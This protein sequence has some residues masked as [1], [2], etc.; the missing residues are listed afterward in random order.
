MLR[1]LLGVKMMRSF[2]SA[3]AEAGDDG[4]H[5]VVT[6]L[7]ISFYGPGDTSSNPALK[8]KPWYRIEK[9]LL[10][11]RCQQTAWLYVAE[12]QQEDLTQ[13]DLVITEMRHDN[14]HNTSSNASPNKEKSWELQPGGLWVLKSP[15]TGSE[16][17]AITGVDV[18]FGVDA[19]EPR[20]QW[21]LMRAPLQLKAPP[22]LPIARITARYGRAKLPS[23]DSRIPLRVRK[24]GTFKVVQISDTHMVTGVG[25]CRDAIDA[26]GIPLPV[27]EADPGTVKFIGEILDVEKTDLVVLTGDQLHH[28]ALDI[29]SAIFKVVAPLIERSIPYAVVFGNHDDEDDNALSRE[30]MSSNVFWC[31]RGQS[32]SSS[33]IAIVFQIQH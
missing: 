27:S 13:D 19:I 9:N 21:T 12:M 30:S 4:I 29:Q 28:G 5:R 16:Y 2:I 32:M 33:N 18:L 26:H 14:P 1:L 3:G 6:D 11:H 7:T 20:P 25:V 10:L 8:S 15:Y 24:D 31:R 17:Q 22:D 23:G